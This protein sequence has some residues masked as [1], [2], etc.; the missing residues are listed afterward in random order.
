MNYTEHSLQGLRYLIRYPS[1]FQD[2]RSYPILVFLHG[3]GS[4]GQDMQNLVTN[5]FFEEI[6]KFPDFPFLVVAPL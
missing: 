4:R 6:E 2:N 1:G 5:P 3:A